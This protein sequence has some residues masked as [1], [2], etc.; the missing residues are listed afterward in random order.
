MIANFFYA[1]DCGDL[2]VLIDGDDVVVN[3][4]SLPHLLTRKNLQKLDNGVA[5]AHSYYRVIKAGEENKKECTLNT[6]KHCVLR[7]LVEEGLPQNVAIIRRGMLIT[8]DQKMLKQWRGCSDFAA[9][10]VC[11]SD[12]GNAL[13]RRMETP[14]HDAFE[15]ERLRTEARK[16]KKALKELTDWI[17]KEVKAAA[18]SKIDE[19]TPLIK[20]RKFFPAPDDSL[21]GEQSERDFEGDSQI[22]LKPTKLKPEPS[23]DVDDEDAD[24]NG[25]GNGDG[26]GNGNGNGDDGRKPKRA[27]VMKIEAVRILS[28]SDND[29]VKRVIFTPKESGKGFLSLQIAGDSFTETIRIIKA[30]GGDAEA[31]NGGV[32][33]TVAPD[34]VEAA[35]RVEL[36]VKLANAVGDS[37]SVTLAKVENEVG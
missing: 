12:E 13:L 9:V 14:A 28:D 15:P 30:E 25:G 7:T 2:E 10:C 35:D 6:L 5:N 31:K 32:L 3:A 16:G 24:E 20:L 18:E 26:N 19:V 33:L 17:R 34:R 4:E 27:P 21:P 36:R 1:I 29:A 11:E 37:L 23:A 8:D 22:T